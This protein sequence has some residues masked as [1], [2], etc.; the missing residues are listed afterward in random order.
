MANYNNNVHKQ[1]NNI[2]HNESLEYNEDLEY[3]RNPEKFCEI[4]SLKLNSKCIK[5][6]CTHCFHYNCLVYSLNNCNEQY[7]NMQC[8][9]CRKKIDYIP[10]LENEKPIKNLHKEY[11]EY[12]KKKNE[13]YK[14][15]ESVEIIHGK[16]K[17]LT[18]NIVDVSEKMLMIQ[19]NNDNNKIRIKKNNVKIL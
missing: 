12:I 4:C 11:E 19:L 13:K 17:S 9:Y 14:I 6:H 15:N 7:N 10:L 5:L 3:E 18:G 16:Y 8:P 1:N 2:E